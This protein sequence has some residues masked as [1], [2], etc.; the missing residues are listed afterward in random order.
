MAKSFDRWERWIAIVATAALIDR[1]D[2][3]DSFAIATCLLRTSKTLS[4]RRLGGC[5]AKQVSTRDLN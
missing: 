4:T 3:K 5:S 2:L 1:G